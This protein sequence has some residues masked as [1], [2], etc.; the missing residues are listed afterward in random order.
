[1]AH[2]PLKF[3]MLSAL[4]STG[5]LYSHAGERQIRNIIS[6]PA[7]REVDPQSTGTQ[8]YDLW[9]MRGA[10]PSAPGLAMPE[11]RIPDTYPS[12]QEHGYE[13]EG[14]ASFLNEPMITEAPSPLVLDQENSPQSRYDASHEEQ[15]TAARNRKGIR[16]RRRKPRAGTD[17]AAPAASARKHDSQ[18]ED[19]FLQ[20]EEPAS[21]NP[22]QSFSQS[23]SESVESENTT[24]GAYDPFAPQSIWDTE[25][26]PQQ[27]SAPQEDMVSDTTHSE[28]MYYDKYSDI[29]PMPDNDSGLN[30][31]ETSSPDRASAEEENYQHEFPEEEMFTQPSLNRDPQ[32]D[33]TR[34]EGL[35]TN[36]SL[37]SPRHLTVQ[38]DFSRYD[39]KYNP[40]QPQ[41]NQQDAAANHEEE[42]NLNISQQRD[43]ERQQK[44]LE[45]MQEQLAQQQQVMQQ[46]MVEQQMLQEQIAQRQSSQNNALA[47]LPEKR[48]STPPPSLPT[49]SEVEDY[50]QR[51]ELRLLE[52]YNNLPDHAGNVGRVEVVLSKPLEESLD[53]SRIRAEFDQLVYDPWGRRIPKLEEEYFVVTFAAGGA[54]QVRSDPSVRVG[55]DHEQGYSERM[56][57]SADPFGKVQSS[58]AFSPAPAPKTQEKKMPNWWRPDFPELQ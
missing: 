37:R 26:I 9:P 1:M 13:P 29:V 40:S 15:P 6:K 5:C 4:L 21:S 39:S 24:Y 8:N 34:S 30:Q 14:T 56:P 45:Q 49:R 51:L 11:E 43:F 55:L 3:F 46:Q 58:K 44:L 27:S 41:F 16:T 57:L 25:T 22:N 53:G 33:F 7:T 18:A 38:E 42:Q 54:R 48:N 50:R 20:P 31:N 10:V 47:T 2:S 36:D 28:S 52:R 32:G 35:T 17:A 12:S 19:P 23:T